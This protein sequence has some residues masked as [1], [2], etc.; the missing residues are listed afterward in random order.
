MKISIA[1]IDVS[2]KNKTDNLNQVRQLLSSSKAVGDL[3]LLPEL[4]TTG[5]I[6][7]Q[8]KDI[9]RLS[10]EYGNSETIDSLTELA[11]QYAT[12]IVAGISERD[13]GQY[14]NAV[15]VVDKNGLQA[16]YRKISQTNIDKHYFSRGCEPVTFRYKGITFGIAICFDLW[17]PEIIREYVR[18]GVDVLL[19]PANFGGQQSHYISRARAVENGMHVVTC[20]RIGRDVTEKLTG[21]YCGGSQIC[22]PSGE[23]LVKL[24]DQQVLATV[25][26]QIEGGDP[27]KIIGVNLRD[28]METLSDILV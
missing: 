18:S 2:Y 5:Y 21:E 7:D 12:M 15:A 3:V 14:F 28:E 10:E 25:D 27:R 4:F 26:V 8:P 9:H 23:L 16:R 1:Q 19:H 20:N 22:T 6:F 11:R 13:Q 17:F 24:D